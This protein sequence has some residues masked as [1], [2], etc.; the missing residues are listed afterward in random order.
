MLWQS[1]FWS[2]GPRSLGI[3]F[4]TLGSVCALTLNHDEAAKGGGYGVEE[5]EV[6]EEVEE[7]AQDGDGNTLS[8]G[9]DLIGV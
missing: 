9:M 6:V 2:I 4:V 8:N 7:G 3:W 5:V 1:Q